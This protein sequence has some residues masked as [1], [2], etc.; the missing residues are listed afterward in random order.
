[1]TGQL[2]LVGS[3][4]EAPQSSFFIGASVICSHARPE[5]ILFPAAASVASLVFENGDGASARI[6]CR[7]TSS[8]P[9]G[10][11]TDQLVSNV[12]VPLHLGATNDIKPTFTS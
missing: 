3:Q 9:L 5:S 11:V 2:Q 1:M 4:G 7:A 12:T 8:P 10:N 6:I